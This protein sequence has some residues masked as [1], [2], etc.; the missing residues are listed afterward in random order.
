MSASGTKLPKPMRQAC[1]QLVKADVATAASDATHAVSDP[2]A[3]ASGDS[4]SAH[5][6][7][8]TEKATKPIAVGFLHLVGRRCTQELHVIRGIS[9]W[10]LAR[11]ASW[12]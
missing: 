2:W 3:A 11:H 7:V 6:M 1:P 9:C 12:S 5:L 8:V 10:V 4:A